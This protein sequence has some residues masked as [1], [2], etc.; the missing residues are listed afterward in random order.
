MPRSVQTVQTIEDVRRG[1]HT[2][3]AVCRNAGCRYVKKVDIPLL[4]RKVDPRTRL[5]PGPHERHFTDSMRCSGCR[6]RGVYLWVEPAE[7]KREIV[8]KSTPP[9]LPNFVIVSEGPGGNDVIATADNLM[10]GRGAYVAAAL[11]HPDRRI[12]LKQGAFVI[13]DS[14]SGKP[15]KVMTEEQFSQMRASEHFLA[16]N[17]IPQLKV[18]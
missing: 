7:Q 18:S 15:I 2:L 4:L 8:A 11:F 6:W 12:V 5:R 3:Y 9:K 16:H 14:K 1:G 17:S 13:E 10:V